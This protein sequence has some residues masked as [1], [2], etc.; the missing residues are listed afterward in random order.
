MSYDDMSC[1][2]P[3]REEL[4][5]EYGA[6]SNEFEAGLALSRRE[7]SPDDRG[8]IRRA[9][10]EGRFVVVASMPRFCSLTDALMGEYLSLVSEHGTQAEAD[11]ALPESNEEMSYEVRGPV[12]ARREV[13]VDQGDDLPF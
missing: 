2:D 4:E 12:V 3:A 7:A 8:A 5:A 6:F 11:A 9:V 10:M 13:V 1:V